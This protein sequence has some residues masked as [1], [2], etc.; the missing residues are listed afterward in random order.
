M[1]RQAGGLVKETLP[2]REPRWLARKSEVK[3][4]STEE[5]ED[6][7]VLEAAYP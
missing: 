7:A 4:S 6:T 3:R 5:E 2:L 1:F